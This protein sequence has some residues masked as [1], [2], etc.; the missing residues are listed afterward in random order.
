MDTAFDS[1][2]PQPY[3]GRQTAAAATAAA[4]AAAGHAAKQQRLQLEWS[5][6][7]LKQLQPQDKQQLPSSS[8]TTTN[9]T[10]TTSTTSTTSATP[11]SQ[12][13]QTP[14]V[15]GA[16]LPDSTSLSALSLSRGM[17]TTPVPVPVAPAAMYMSSGRCLARMLQMN[18]LLNHNRL[19]S[20]GWWQ[21]FTTEFFA[22]D[23]IIQYSLW[24]SVD[25]TTR[26]FDFPAALL[27]RFY[28]AHFDSGITE[29]A[30]LMKTPRE[31]PRDSSKAPV[32][33]ESNVASLLHGF[34]KTTQVTF[35]GQFQAT[36][37]QDAKIT[38]WRF[39]VQNFRE[40]V[41]RDAVAAVLP[42]P[43]PIN[44][45]GMTK[46]VMRCL[47]LAENVVHLD[48]IIS[49]SGANTSP[50]DIMGLIISERLQ[51]ILQRERQRSEYPLPPF[52]NNSGQQS[53]PDRAFEFHAGAD[54]HERSVGSTS[55]DTFLP[56][57]QE[58]NV[59]AW[60]G[61]RIPY[62]PHP[63]TSNKP[64]ASTG[65]VAV[66]KPDPASTQATPSIVAVL[67]AAREASLLH[68]LANLTPEQRVAAMQAIGK[69]A[70]QTTHV[71]YLAH[72][73]KTTLSQP[74]VHSPNEFMNE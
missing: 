12:A 39:D 16:R 24:N 71:N 28:K 32:L 36:F 17:M 3:L 6:T 65:S 72:S 46:P 4:Q 62:S 52:T 27:P 15:Q 49:A 26:S 55:Y 59:Q 8:T 9:T 74:S 41:L 53:V 29:L 21:Q 40:Y 38:C 48:D 61:S 13:Q 73:P 5:A 51:L 54:D 23:A 47:E 45:Y 66:G 10:T 44:E 7:M 2:F 50:A 11:Q 42:P 19:N 37:D 31:L 35:N 70:T 69:T 1:A 63:V 64:Q 56:A 34:D 22:T 67:N 14:A 68:S 33:L 60:L 25:G 30:L 43:S 18:E 58:A 20:L 57:N